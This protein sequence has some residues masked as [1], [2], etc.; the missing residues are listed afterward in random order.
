MNIDN[1]LH[2]QIVFYI[3]NYKSYK[4]ISEI[5][6][7]PYFEIVKYCNQKGITKKKVLDERTI[8]LFRNYNNKKVA[9]ILDISEYRANYLR[10]KFG[11][12]RNRPS[13]KVQNILSD[14]NAGLTQ[15]EIAKKYNVSKQY[16]N[17]IIKEY[18]K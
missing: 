14:Y 4:E 18:I 1:D 8:E 11:V 2:N 7:L 5:L 15:T 6:K 10:E 9:E 13:D 3:E 17:Q 12:K 16:I